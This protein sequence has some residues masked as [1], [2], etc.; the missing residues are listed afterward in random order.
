MAALEVRV[1]VRVAWWV[2]LYLRSVSAFA[3]LHGLSPD[4]RKVERVVRA[5]TR[6]VLLDTRGRPMRAARRRS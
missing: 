6:V 2:R 3:A 4:M 1:V 5:G